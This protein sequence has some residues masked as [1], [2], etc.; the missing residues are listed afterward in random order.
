MHTRTDLRSDVVRRAA[1][2]HGSTVADDV[3]LAHAEVCDLDVAVPIQQHVVQLQ[4]SA[5]V[6]HMHGRLKNAL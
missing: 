5:S 4:V 1:E 6:S 3:L 2:R